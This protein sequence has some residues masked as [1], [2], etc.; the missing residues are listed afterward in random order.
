MATTN[1]SAL[2]RKVLDIIKATEPVGY[3]NG[4][5]TEDRRQASGADVV[6]MLCELEPELRAALEPAAERVAYVRETQQYGAVVMQPDDD[7]TRAFCEK[8]GKRTVTFPII[9]MLKAAGYVVRTRPV[10]GRT[11]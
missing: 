2:L 8:A 11:L 3:M 1:H 4:L 9:G 5:A 6:G 7:I 10:E